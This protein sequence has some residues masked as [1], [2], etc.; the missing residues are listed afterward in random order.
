M[1]ADD[2]VPT[3]VEVGQHLQVPENALRNGSEAVP[4]Q[5]EGDQA[6]GIT[7]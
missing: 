2:V 4:G 1:E 7:L 6:S 3:E 5:D